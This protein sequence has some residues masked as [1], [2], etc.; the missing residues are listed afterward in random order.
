MRSFKETKSNLLINSQ[1]LQTSKTPRSFGI[2]KVSKGS[3]IG[4]LPTSN[5][6]PSKSSS[7]KQKSI[8][9]I[10]K[11]QR[12]SCKEEC[13]FN[14]VKEPEKKD[15]ANNE[16]DKCIM[17]IEQELTQLKKLTKCTKQTICHSA[18]RQKHCTIC[19]DSEKMLR[20][21]CNILNSK[22]DTTKILER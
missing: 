7:I 6:R 15:D 12:P 21:I 5:N 22:Y 9:R 16:T 3:D 19:N 4:S 18:L 20:L 10:T 8:K 2:N 11:H 1:K 17:Q 13:P 14:L